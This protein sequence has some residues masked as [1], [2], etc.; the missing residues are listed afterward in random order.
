MQTE[1]PHPLKDNSSMH[2]PFMTL[3][4]TRHIGQK[5]SWRWDLKT[6]VMTWSEQLY[7]IAGCDPQAAIP[8]FREHSRFYT[9]E[10]WNRLTGAV[11]E[12]FK[13]GVPYELE[14]QMCRPD[15]TKRRIIG[16]GEAVRDASND[17]RQLHGTVVDISE[18]RP[19][20]DTQRNAAVHTAGDIDHST[21]CLIDAHEEERAR[22][23]REL[24]DDICQSLSLVAA[25]IQRL[26]PAFPEITK[27]AQTR[28]DELSQQ[29]VATID[30]ISRVSLGL[31]PA[32]LD[33][34]DLGVAIRGLCRDFTK[35]YKIR[36]QCSAK[37]PTELDKRLA[38]S[39]F[40]VCQESL[41]NISKHSG[42]QN[43]QIELMVSSEELLLR[44]TDDGVGFEPEK[45]RSASGFGFVRMK[46][47]LLLIGGEL[48]VWSQP[49]FGTRL[50]ARAPLTEP[51]RESDV[52]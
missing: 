52:A 4:D 50:E 26:V 11:L 28:I 9:A 43:V 8:S 45:A 20:A 40:R 30:K 14:L 6:D 27:E 34:V 37:V 44:A 48:A 49:S 17:I 18:H 33:F 42:A 1:Y 39:F 46:E 47:Q 7:R 21:K 23:S 12:V 29:T 16:R 41:R 10:S 25:E 5:G 24:S 13:T 19:G 35:Q 32:V 31:R 3:Q 2:N 22:I 51:A 38:L 15:G 36:V